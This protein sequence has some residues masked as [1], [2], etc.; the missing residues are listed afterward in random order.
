[1]TSHDHHHTHSAGCCAAGAG[2]AGK[3]QDVVR[4]PVCGMTVDP[5]AGKPSSRA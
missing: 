2:A 3:A 4:D 5:E 1:M